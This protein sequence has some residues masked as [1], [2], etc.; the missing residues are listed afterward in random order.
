MYSVCLFCF[1]CFLFPNITINH[2][3][4]YKKNEQR[5]MIRGGHQTIPP[6]WTFIFL[7]LPPT[8]PKGL[9]DAILLLHVG[10]SFQPVVVLQILC[11]ELISDL[12]SPLCTE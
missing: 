5:V 10:D 6:E 9:D 8:M 4:T 3:K 11:T 2:L 7:F 12:Y 1:V